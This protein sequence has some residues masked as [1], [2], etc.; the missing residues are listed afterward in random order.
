MLKTLRKK[1][2]DKELES[3]FIQNCGKNCELKKHTPIFSV[4]AASE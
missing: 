3:E 1:K 4:P 2:K